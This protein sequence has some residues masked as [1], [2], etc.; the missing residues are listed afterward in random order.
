MLVLWMENYGGH[1]DTEGEWNLLFHFID[2]SVLL[3]SCVCQAN[4]NDGIQ[5]FAVDLDQKY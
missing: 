3:T 4:V 1:W 2:N 5:W